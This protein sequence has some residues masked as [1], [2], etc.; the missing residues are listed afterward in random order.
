MTTKCK[1]N[2]AMICYNFV[3]AP[4]FKIQNPEDVIKIRAKTFVI[5]M[6]CLIDCDVLCFLLPP[7]LRVDSRNMTKRTSYASSSSPGSLVKSRF[8]RILVSNL[9]YSDMSMTTGLHVV[10]QQVAG[11]RIRSLFWILT[12]EF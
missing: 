5:S 8:N 10:S 1:K 2:D 12:P 6:G 4:S 3:T 7:I 11:W 9:V